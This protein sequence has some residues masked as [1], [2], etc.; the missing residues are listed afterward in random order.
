MHGDKIKA[1]QD[2]IGGIGGNVGEVPAERLAKVF[3]LSY[4]DAVDWAK[5]ID[6]AQIGWRLVVGRRGAKTRLIRLDKINV[7]PQSAKIENDSKAASETENINF[8]EA[9]LVEIHFTLRFGFT[10]SFKVPSD[11]KKS[12]IERLAHFIAELPVSE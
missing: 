4:R 7:P 11:I 3:H 12:E 6:E 2:F 9:D 10:I 1:F 5:E 8:N